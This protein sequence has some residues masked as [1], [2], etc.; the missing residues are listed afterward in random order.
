MTVQLNQDHD[1]YEWK[2]N[3]Q[4]HTNYK[5]GILYEYLSEQRPDVPWHFVVW[6]SK[7]IPRHSFHLW[8]VIQNRLP[9]RDRLI[10]WGI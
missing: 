1:Y 7:A 2:V 3:G 8:L 9:T 5:T 10:Q 6:H 4:R